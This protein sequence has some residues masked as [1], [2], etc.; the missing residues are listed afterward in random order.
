MPDSEATLHTPVTAHLDSLAEAIAAK[1]PERVAGHYEP[2]IL[3]YD[4]APPLSRRGADALTESLAAWFSTFVGPVGL[5]ARDLAVM[6]DGDLAVVTGFLRITG[7]RTDG[8]RTDVWA[9]ATWCLRREHGH[10]RI[11]HEHTSV[12]FHM[13]GSDRAALDLQP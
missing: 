11:A 9:R 4:L 10:W 3:L 8:A 7:D 13:D 12:P 1:D 2:G 6:Q 5:A